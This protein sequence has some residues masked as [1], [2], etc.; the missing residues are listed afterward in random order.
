MKLTEGGNAETQSGKHGCRHRYINNKTYVRIHVF[1]ET[2]RHYTTPVRH[3]TN[4][5]RDLL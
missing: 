5:Q 2:H 1:Y 3:Y 4:N